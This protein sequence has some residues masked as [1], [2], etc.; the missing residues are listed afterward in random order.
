MDKEL[1]KE[2]RIEGQQIYLRPITRE[3]TPN[4]VRW[5]N[6]ETFFYLSEAFY[7]RRPFEMAG[8]GGGNERMLSIH[9]LSEGG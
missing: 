9:R 5:R 6:S 7:R 4:I 1:D 3:D 8:N 2:L